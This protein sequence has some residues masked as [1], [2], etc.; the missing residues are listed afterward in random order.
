MF[1]TK[2]MF[3]T[4][5][6]GEMDRL[7]TEMKDLFEATPKHG[8]LNPK[9]TEMPQV[10]MWTDPDQITLNAELPGI[11][12]EKLNVRAIDDI[13][14]IEGERE[15]PEKPDEKN[16]VIYHRRERTNGKFRRAFQLP[17]KIDPDKIE[18]KYSKGVLHIVL[19]RLEADKPKKI[20]ISV[21]S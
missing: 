13:I 3:H 10:N 8:R 20:N 19:P 5:P 18:A 9:S 12:I 4:T 11:D 7:L 21:S 2:R 17:Y 6:W 15:L 16:G 14:S 1:V